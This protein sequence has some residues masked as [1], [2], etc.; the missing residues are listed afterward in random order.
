[1]KNVL[2]I[3]GHDLSSG[4][5]ITKDAEIFSALKC[6]PLTVPTALV[7]QGPKGV[8]DVYPTPPKR[9]EL[10]LRALTEEIAP[11]GIKIGVACDVSQVEIIA[12]FLTTQ[13]DVP[14]VLDP[15]FKAKNGHELLSEAGRRALVEK[16]LPAVSLITPNTEEAGF[17]TGLKTIDRDAMRDAAQ[18]LKEKGAK[19]VLI[20]GG[21]LSGEPADLL[22]EEEGRITWWEKRRINRTIHGTGC[23]L[24]SLVLAYLAHGLPLGEA[25]RLAE[26]TID[27]ML[28]NSYQIGPEGYYYTSLTLLKGCSAERW[29]VVS[30]LKGAMERFVLLNMVDLIPEVQMNLGYAVPNP[31]GVEDVA[32][33]PGRIGCLQGRVLIK[34]EPSFGVSSHVARLILTYMTRFPF[35]RAGA[36]IRFAKEILDQAKGKGM[37]IALTDCTR[38]PDALKEE[39]GK[40][41][42][43]LVWKALKGTTAPPD[44]IYDLGDK[45]KEPIVRLF[46]RDPE[47]LLHKMEIIRPWRIS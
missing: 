19:S 25:F 7:I 23:T 20:K 22:L 42:D 37:K 18:S 44:I 6:H 24:S 14:I 3:A 35:M 39:D 11:D 5:G 15:V 34:D 26:K 13:K 38:E 10:M 43:F 46:A 17:L 41:L 1:M 33:F 16:I 29:E 36:N 47:E 45:G 8:R 27:E 2:T 32:A 31:R 40:G 9:L 12:A 28:K 4:A 21:H 30:A